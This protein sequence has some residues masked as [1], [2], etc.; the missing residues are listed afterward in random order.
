MSTVNEKVGSA[1]EELI[2]INNDRYQGYKTAADET[3]DP[4][5]KELFTKYS[6]QSMNFG[7]EL[8]RFSNYTEETP[9]RDETKLSGKFY[10]AWMDVKS[11]LTGHDR[12]A[13]LGSC[14]YGEDVALKSYNTV[15]ED[16][17]NLPSEVLT[18]IQNQKMELQEAHDRVKFMR[19]SA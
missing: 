16:S 11:A 5:L 6:M 14:E 10:R 3:N 12:K 15:L 13:I 7:S 19:D 1:L 2:I 17:E 4:D 18:V 9:D 8:R